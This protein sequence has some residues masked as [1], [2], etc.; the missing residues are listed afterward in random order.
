MRSMLAPIRRYPFAA[1]LVLTAVLSWGPSIAA[2]HSLVPFGPLLAAVIVLGA[3]DGR[4]SI[5]DLFRR[6]L[7]RAAYARTYLLAC[8]VAPLSIAAGAAVVN[9]ALGATVS[10]RWPID[11]VE[12]VTGTIFLLVF[13][14][15]GEEIG[16]RGFALPRLMTRYSPLAASL[17]LAGIHI[18]WH[19]PLFGT[20]FTASQ[21][22]PWALTLTG[23]TIFMT[24]IM[25]KTNGNVF[26]PVLF[27]TMVNVG[28][29]VFFGRLFSGAALVQMYWL[30][31]LG[32][33]V[34]AAALVVRSGPS[35]GARSTLTTAPVAPREQLTAPRPL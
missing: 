35:L 20:D 7:P 13:I 30:W 2:P 24:W 5:R 4:A 26:G 33:V 27:H 23:A 6:A 8:V 32:Y 1:F 34:L 18:A 17:L 11:P 10:G 15:M 16:W 14:G 12:L 29:M 21:I 3:T 9:V 22:A 28:G 25:N 31:A 19:W